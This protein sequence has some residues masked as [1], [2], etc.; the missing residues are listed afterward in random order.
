MLE[1]LTIHNYAI[2]D[3]MT[4]NFTGGLTVITGETGAGKSIV[5][6]ALELVLGARASSEMIRS[7]ANALEITGIFSPENSIDTLN[8]PAAEGNDDGLLIIRREVRTDGTSRC[9]IN[10]RPVTLKTLKGIGDCLV[11]LHG[12]HDHQSLLNSSG[13]VDFLDGF[14]GLI[15]LAGEVEQLLNEFI[16]VRNSIKKLKQQIENA[17]RDR[18]LYHYQINEID[19]A[20]IVPGEDTELEQ[21]IQK[22]SRAA[23]LKE[24]GW[25]AFQE[26]SESEGSVEEVLGRLTGNIEELSRSDPSLTSF[27][28]QAE[29][30]AAGVSELAG[31]FRQYAD[32]IDDDPAALAELED[33]LYPFRRVMET[34]VRRAVEE[35]D[36]CEGEQQ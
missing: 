13:H 3:E 32:E 14:A 11:D 21:A 33:Y 35:R 6:D 24:L 19:G 7:G 34:A 26:L 30:L 28:E 22:L 2:I 25:R 27:T 15:P 1:S 29:V 5:V 23:E 31:A 18:E 4:V 20:S 16:S 12:Q 17:C 9:F 8:F 36:A 10:D